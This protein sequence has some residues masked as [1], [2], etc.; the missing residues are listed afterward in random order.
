MVSLPWPRVARCGP[1]ST[2]HPARS[3]RGY[4]TAG[5]HTTGPRAGPAN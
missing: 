3:G 4:R 1:E 5:Q 2:D